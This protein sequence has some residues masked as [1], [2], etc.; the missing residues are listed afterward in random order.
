MCA[1]MQPNHVAPRV[2]AVLGPTNTG[3]THFAI[4]RMLG[5]ASGMIGLPLRLLAREV[6]EK[7]ASAKGAH[8]V[9][10]ITGEEKIVP[11]SPTHWV[12]TVESMPLDIETE[13]LAIDEI[14]LAADAER[15]HVFTDRLLHARGR[16]E[17]IFLG[18]DTMRPLLQKLVPGVQFIARPR[19][20]D[21][22][23]TGARKLTRLPRRSAIV[24]FSADAVYSIAELVRRQRGGAAVV[25]GALSPRT[26]NA[27]VALY[28]SGDVD[29]MV[30]TD[31]I[32]MGLNMDIDHVAFAATEKF[33]GAVRRPLRPQELAQIAGRAGRHMNDGTFGVTAEA[34]PFDGETV[35]AIEN[36]RFDPVRVAQWRNPNLNFASITLLD[37]SLDALPPARGLTRARAA[38]DHLVL[39]ILGETEEVKAKCQGPAA[40]KQ[41]WQVCQIPDFRKVAV[42]EHARLVG[43]IYEHLMSHDG[44][45]P[46]DWI[47]GH[48]ARLDV[49]EGDIDAIAQRIAHIRTWTYVS[50]RPGWLKDNAH[51]QERTRA[52]E[53][54]LSDALHERLTQRFVDR[55]TSVLMRRL[56]EDEEFAATIDEAGEVL[57]DGEFVGKLQGFSF[58]PDPRAIGIHGR[59]LRAA[60]LKGLAGEIAARAHALTNAPEAAITLSEHGRLWWNGAI[61]AKLAK[62]S[63]PLRPRVELLADDILTPTAQERA[64]ERLEE[65]VAHHIAKHLAPLLA[66][67]SEL[68]EQ[69][70]TVEPTPP[71]PQAVEPS[72]EASDDTTD[73]GEPVE[74]QTT[75]PEIGATTES[76]STAKQPLKGM[77]RGLAFRLYENLGSVARAVVVRD[78]RAIDQADRAPLRRLGVRFGAFSVFLPALVKPAAARLK[79]LLWAVHQGI[80]DVPPP[81]PAGLTSIAADESIAAGFYEA[82]GFRVCGPRAVRVDML[83]RLGDLIRSKGDNKQMP[84]SFSVSPDMM[85]ILGCG[86]EDLT[87]ILRAIGF[88]DGSEKKEDGSE[89]VVWKLRNR[90][91][92]RLVEPPK[93]VERKPHRQPKPEGTQKDGGRKGPRPEKSQPAS[94]ATAAE[95]PAR[96]D[97]RQDRKNEPRASEQRREKPFKVDPDSPFAALA[98]LKFRK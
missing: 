46:D 69:P 49:T 89:T 43:S 67:H 78:L 81:P 59:A 83:E 16:S 71:S 54:K 4:E 82:A 63:D 53:D 26:R 19:F 88:R 35:E 85:S 58:V 27:Q 42:E 17:T 68:Q 73:V 1:A 84:Q 75:E 80:S 7:V 25:M 77:A 64:S 90:R 86:E 62:G 66:L 18:S 97:K 3:K 50:N 30:A 28:Q 65:W 14:Q 40:V 8:A 36:H 95:K 57:V 45:L 29:F 44:V 47:A 15:G 98:A 38:D 70:A 9:A 34:E 41:L 2:L 76:V 55:R 48:V 33:D 23:Y 31:A 39:R 96:P 37:Q 92:E 20:S 12:A 5:H 22:A 91:E 13:F 56:R 10:L 60:A 52:V 94:D 32:G 93:R 87:L 51:W 11:K 21:L 79:A 6:Y 61:V 74:T 72:T 24:A